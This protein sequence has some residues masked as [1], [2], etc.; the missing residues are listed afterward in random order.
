MTKAKIVANIS[1]KTGLEKS[2]IQV[3]VDSFMEEVKSAMG[4]GNNVFLRGFGSFVVKRRAK[5]TGRNI[6]KNTSIII[7]AHNIPFFKPAKTFVEEVKKRVPVGVH[8][9][10]H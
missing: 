8:D 7:P 3:I 9:K 1:K 10:F 4:S 5:K 2:E 6:M